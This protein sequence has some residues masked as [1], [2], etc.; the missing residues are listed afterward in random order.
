[1]LR[2]HIGLVQQEP[3]LFGTSIAEN[4]RYGY[5]E[6]TLEEIE[7]ACKSSN[8]H[9]FIESFPDGY[10]TQVGDMGGKLSG[11]Q[12][13]RIAIA[14]VLVRHPKILLL[15]EAT[16]ALDTDSERQVQKSID[17]LMKS[18]KHKRTTVIIAH[19]L[20]TI[21]NAD[22]IVVVSDG[23]VMETGTH[24]ELMEHKGEYYNLVENQ[25]H[26]K[27]P[28]EKRAS[29]EEIAS[30]QSSSASESLAVNDDHPIVRFQS[31]RF[32][33]P[34]R[35]ENEIFRKLNLSIRR[36]ENLA[37]V[38]PSG[39]G[40]SSIIALLERFYNPDD[41]EIFVNGLPL[42]SL[43]VSWWHKQV[44]LVGQEPVLFD[45]SIGENIAFGM[46]IDNVTQ[47]QIE[48]AA[49]EANCHDFIMEFPYGYNTHITSGLVS[50][51]QKQ[52]ICIARALLRKP[53]ILLLDEATSA[54][55][56][57]SERIVQQSID[58]VTANA[59]LTTVMIA[60]RLSSI[61]KADRIAVILDGKVKEIGT[62]EELMAKPKGHFR[63]LQEIQFG[64]D[65]GA[66]KSRKKKDKKKKK[67]LEKE[68][69]EEDEEDDIDKD[70]EKSNAKRARMMAKNDG[71]Y[72]FIGGI[73]ALLAGA[74]YPA[75]G[76]IFAY[77]IELLYSPVLPDQLDGY[78]STV[79]D[80][81]KTLA[82]NIAFG[83]LG[84]I[85]ASLIG[86]ILLYYGFGVAVER[87]NQRVR[88]DAFKSLCRQECGYFDAKPV[89]KITSE[90]QDD[91]AMIHSFTGEP[92]RSLIVSL[93]SVLVG[94]VIGFYFMW[95]FALL[96]IGI[97]PFLAFGAEMEMQMY[98]NGEDE[99]DDTVEDE[100][101]PGG[102]V[103]ESLLN[104]RTI[105]SLSMEETKLTEYSEAL[106]HQ[107][108][109]PLRNNCVKGC[110]S[111]LGQFFQYWGIGLMV[112]DMC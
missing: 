56:S 70:K 39:G 15:D 108:A 77:T 54:L 13:Q 42:T 47:Q 71:V 43:N 112:S 4:I 104:V 21:R 31:V 33:Y 92:I 81:M 35:P 6:A 9:E 79:V 26:G 55:D 83:S 3:K 74:V 37:L 65:P 96:F 52:R 29:T 28:A 51:G 107:D 30:R 20:S 8:A 63:H 17:K 1:W 91:A 94:I 23:K 53:K 103:V 100:N 106:H 32:T 60:H 78:Y 40:K 87:M 10:N 66:M 5:Q 95:P 16:S 59:D 84:T 85:F 99:G 93:S 7:E 76:F 44:A 11:G 24:D 57:E 45:L 72:F 58:K 18:K 111:G 46:G 73:G 101:S 109:H 19:R 90:L 88:D 75:W 89:G 25:T 80:D 98:Y 68:E 64:D 34:T 110:G 69:A 12:K 82:A 22:K 49:K 27:D 61:K 97:L 2:S 48:D 36:G 14:R 105:A 50:G 62:Y 38:G 86:N 102:I 67:K 41:G